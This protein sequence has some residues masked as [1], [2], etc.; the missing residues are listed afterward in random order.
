MREKELAGLAD[1]TESMVSLI[2]RGLR[3]PSIEVKMRLA[4]ALGRQVHQLFP[5]TLS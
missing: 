3:D 2:E 1:I 5:P 4:R